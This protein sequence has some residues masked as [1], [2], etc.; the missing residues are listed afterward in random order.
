MYRH[1]PQ[2]NPHQEMERDNFPQS[3]VEMW[4][5]QVK[6]LCLVG[7]FPQHLKVLPWHEVKV[8]L[9]EAFPRHLVEVLP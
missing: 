3:K 8:S 5:V 2:G 7:A 4:G 1:T 6:V 9:V